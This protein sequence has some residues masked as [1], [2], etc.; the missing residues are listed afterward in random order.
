LL[1]CLGPC[2]GVIPISGCYVFSLSQINLLG[3]VTGYRLCEWKLGFLHSRG[4]HFVVQRQ[5]CFY[6]HL[7]SSAV[8][9]RVFNAGVKRLCCGISVLNF[10]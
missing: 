3:I 8:D 9:I 4:R 7:A 5:A 6:C 2:I 10:M 1:S